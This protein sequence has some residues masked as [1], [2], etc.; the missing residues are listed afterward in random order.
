MLARSFIVLLSEPGG[1]K[2]IAPQNFVKCMMFSVISK[3]KMTFLCI[4]K[5]YRIL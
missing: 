1:F 3:Q 2:E 5:L 4:S